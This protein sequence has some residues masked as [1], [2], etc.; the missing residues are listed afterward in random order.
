MACT[1][2]ALEGRD[3]ACGQCTIAGT[4][5][6]MWQESM[7]SLHSLC[8][9]GDPCDLQPLAGQKLDSPSNHADRSLYDSD[10]VLCNL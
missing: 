5:E 7:G 6:S 10:V 9:G 3:G 4:G 8:S 2:H 1:T